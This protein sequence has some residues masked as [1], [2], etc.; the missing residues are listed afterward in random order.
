M[1]INN[2]V[3][4]Y[5]HIRDEIERLLPHNVERI[6]EVGCGRGETL[7][8][9]KRCKGAQFAC[10]I[11]LVSDYAAEAAQKIDW[12]ATGNFETLALPP[13][14]IDFDVILCLDVLEHFVDPWESIRRL[15]LLLRPG[16]VLIASIPN[17]RYFRVVL[18]LL[19]QGRWDYEDS[20]ILDRTHL[21]FFTRSTA[22]EL[23]QSSGL[24]LTEI[25]STGLEKGRKTRY[26]NMMTFSLI[27]PLFEYQ[28][29]IKVQKAVR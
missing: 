8:W 7:A 14:M 6:L 26:L 9:I 15:D 2:N 5:S 29:L 16:G 1:A 13:E 17:V 3:N 10:G 23:I 4:Y 19:F 18:A 20:G 11:E 22:L 24:R 25:R 12:V 27:R 21:R 28:Y